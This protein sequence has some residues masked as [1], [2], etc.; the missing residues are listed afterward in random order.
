[1]TPVYLDTAR[2]DAERVQDLVARMT[3]DEKLS[4]ICFAAP[5][6][7]RLGVPAYNWWNEALH[8]VARAGAATVFPQSIALAATFD[9]DLVREIGDIT[10]TEGRAKYNAA[11]AE[12]DRGL[13]K[14]LTFWAPNINI[15]RDPRW[16]R[17]HET[18]GE[19][20]YLTGSMGTAYIKGIQGDGKRLKAAA[21]AK[22]FAAHSGPEQGRHSFNA[23]VS[24][25]DLAETYFP[26][27][28]RC[29][30]EAHV[31]GVMG[32]YNCVNGEPACG[33]HALINDL[34]RE[35]WGFDGYFVSDCGAVKDFHK[36]HKV[37]STVEESA[38]LALTSGCDL[39]CGQVYPHMRQ[40]LA[41]G[42]VTEEDVD[43]AVTHLMMTRMRLGMFDKD[44]PFDA[45]PY[46]END[47]PAH[48]AVAL[49]AAEECL[50]LLKNDGLLPLNAKACKTIAVI[51]P[52]ADTVEILK[53]NYNGTATE[54]YTLLDGIRAVA[55]Q[56]NPDVRLMV[57]EG[58]HLWR[59]NVEALAEPDDRRSEAVAMARRAD[60]VILC[61][62]LNG[63]LEGEEGDANN[64]YAGADKADLLL[65]P[66]QR[67][68]IQEVAA[69]G[70]PIV[71]VNATGSAMA[72]GAE[73]DLCNAVLQVWYPGQMGGLAVGKALFGQVNPSGKLPVT[74]YRTT[75]EL[76]PFTDYAMQGRTYRFMQTE[77]LYPFGYGLSY[78]TFAYTDLTAEPSADGGCTLRAVVTNTSD[79]AGTDVA[80]V[81]V[82]LIGAAGRVPNRS[83]AAFRRVTL[84]PG[85]SAEVV[86]ILSKSTFAEYDAQGR[87]V[88]TA[89]EAELSLGSGQ[90][91]PRTAALMGAAVPTVTIKLGGLQ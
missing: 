63:T 57:S 76:P 39:N 82:R 45:I 38:A 55:K 70:K 46:E 89:A 5:A 10:S 25:Q 85:Q 77:P 18:Y 88:Y 3:L 68:L 33:S 30:Q 52:N 37:T 71:L 64:S 90:P 56:E 87:E 51:G 47:T 32:G 28:R 80:Q 6:I 26:A 40:A 69:V 48:H 53:G 67:R 12:D 62:G 8:G 21:C 9:T 83:L 81:Y 24:A 14:G 86:F 61:V 7:P 15:F 17:G 4:Q 50:V 23:Q 73:A 42:L 58:C 78:S 84:E 66:P 35:E 91:D 43:V 59:E 44:C 22:H 60:A 41:M 29:V 49:T 11:R 2:S 72:L 19:D 65:P 79:R 16:G 1:M 74:F 20:P 31:E 54:H 27:F 13:Y 75:E 36:G 34:L